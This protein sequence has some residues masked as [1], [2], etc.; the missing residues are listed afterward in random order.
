MI[1]FASQAQ[2]IPPVP[3]I[4]TG[5][6]A[7]RDI[8]VPDD[9]PNLSGV[10][11]GQTSNRTITPIDGSSTPFLPWAK[12]YFDTRAKFE[13][14]GQ[15]AYDPTANCLPSGVPRVIANGYPLD[16]VQLPNM[17]IIGVESGH[18]YRVIHLDGKPKP[19]NVP[20]SWLGY[21]VGHWEGD[22]LVVE[23]TG[24]SPYTQVDEEGRPKSKD[25]RVVERYTKR[26]PDVVEILFTM[27]DDRTYTRPWTARSQFK[28]A[29]NVRLAEYIC[30]ENNRNR[31]DK[32]GHLRHGTEK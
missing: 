25:M 17:I 5:D 16:I 32:T 29:P 10:W 26:A 11:L 4:T 18:G 27:Y 9:V 14:A 6:P 22:T 30:E 8:R 2:R 19:A 3:A 23:T 13:A 12:E 15:P 20:D 28:W 7:R 31:P 24:L 21:S 1:P